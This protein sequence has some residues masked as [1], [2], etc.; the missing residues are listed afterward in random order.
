MIAA[1]KPCQYTDGEG[2]GQQPA[3]WP[4][5]TYTAIN[6][7]IED[8][9]YNSPNC[10][11]KEGHDIRVF[12]WGG[13]QERWAPSGVLDISKADGAPTNAERQI[14]NV[15]TSSNSKSDITWKSHSI[16]SS[17]RWNSE[18]TTTTIGTII[19][20]PRPARS[21]YTWINSSSL[22]LLYALPGCNSSFFIPFVDHPGVEKMDW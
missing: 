8:A 9:M 7:D 10:S 18:V 20:M 1:L 2:E 6:V 22:N 15:K 12:L 11:W 13:S 3:F 5:R 14:L 19:C 4:F 16:K 17:I 21:P